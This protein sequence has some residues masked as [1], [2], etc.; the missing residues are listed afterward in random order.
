MESNQQSIGLSDKN[1]TYTKLKSVSIKASAT[2]LVEQHD[3]SHKTSSVSISSSKYASKMKA[4]E[5]KSPS[6]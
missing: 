1:E 4:E 2:N 3:Y 5:F 6:I